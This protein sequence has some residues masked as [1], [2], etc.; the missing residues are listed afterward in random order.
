[1]SASIETQ[2]IEMD[3]ATEAPSVSET[4]ETQK[5]ELVNPVEP[6]S[7]VEAASA[8]EAAPATEAARVG[9]TPEQILAEAKSKIAETFKL[10]GEKLEHFWNAIKVVQGRSRYLKRVVVLTLNDGEKPPQNAQQ[11]EGTGA[12]YLPE[13]FPIPPRR[14]KAKKFKGRGDTRRKGKGR[15]GRFGKSRFHKK[16]RSLNP[17][18]HSRQSE[19]AAIG[20]EGSE[21]TS[22]KPLTTPVISD[23]E[24]S[25]ATTTA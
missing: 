20:V 22:K 16:R 4:H 11:V 24:N 7:V 21:A 9:P 5:A 14:K 2:A 15:G 13:Y 18:G 8:T 10:E 1:V 17:D 25:Q 3:P 12:Y 23:P 6:V 19:S